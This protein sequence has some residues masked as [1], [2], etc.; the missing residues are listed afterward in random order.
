MLPPSYIL[1]LY[2]KIPLVRNSYLRLRC[3]GD[4]VFTRPPIG[5]PLA[6]DAL[7]RV[8]RALRILDAKPRTVV[9]AKIKLRD[10]AVQ[11]LLAAMLVDAL[12]AALEDA[13]NSL[14]AC[15]RARR[16]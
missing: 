15:S 1:A 14:R 3:T 7:K 16:Q 6:D 5:Q 8:R 12:H 11:M 9:V 2:G 13:E 4:G 10:V